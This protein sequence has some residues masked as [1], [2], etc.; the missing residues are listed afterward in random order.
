MG[1]RSGRREEAELKGENERDGGIGGGWG[2]SAVMLLYHTHHRL[3]L[4]LVNICV[5]AHRYGGMLTEGNMLVCT[6]RPLQGG[7]LYIKPPMHL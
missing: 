1:I 5:C 7:L 3:G 6:R 2:S 4:S